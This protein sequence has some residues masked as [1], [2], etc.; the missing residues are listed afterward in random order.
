MDVRIEGICHSY[1]KEK[2]LNN[3]TL[4]ISG[5]TCICI[6]GRNGCGKTTLLTILAG[7]IAP[8]S[9]TIDLGV[10]KVGYVP[11][12]NPLLEDVSVRSNLK[13]WADSKELLDCVVK[14]YDLQEILNKRVNALSGGMKRRLSIACAMVNNPDILILDEPTA[15]LDIEYK[16]LIHSQIKEFVE[17]GGAVIMV[18][19][20]Q[21]ELEMG[22]MC[23]IIQDGLLSELNMHKNI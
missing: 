8:D 21:E 15:A 22:D 5:G 16:A 9:G 10:A 6:T 18:S 23:Y 11:Q 1:G 20:E 13:L 19:H 4:S 7:I 14:K 12:I 2:V 17:A 3:V